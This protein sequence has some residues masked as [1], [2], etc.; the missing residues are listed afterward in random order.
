MPRRVG[1]SYYTDFKFQG[2]RIR[3]VMREARTADQAKRLEAQIRDRYFE[4]S[5]GNPAASHTLVD[6]A[7][8]VWLPWCKDN[9]KSPKG[10]RNDLLYF[11]SI[12]SFFG[13]RTF[14]EIPSLLIERFKRQRLTD[15]LQPASV[16]RELAAL[17]KIFRFAIQQAIA[18]INPVSQ[19]KKLIENNA[20]TRFLSPAE[21]A[22]LFDALL[23]NPTLST[24]VSLAIHTG[25]RQGEILK[26]EWRDV[27]FSQ[28]R[29]HIRDTKSGHDRYVPL[30]ASAR[31]ALGDLPQTRGIR[32]VFPGS[33]SS[34]HLVE[35][36]KAWHSAL[37]AA[38]IENFRF[39]DLRH[40]AGS[41]LA[42]TGAHPNTIKVLLGHRRLE[43][44]ERYMHAME[45]QKREAMAALENFGQT[46]VKEA[47]VLN[48]KQALND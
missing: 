1:N 8:K 38:A 13:N 12:M 18:T 28:S 39:H 36:K 9:R 43:T 3:K 42:A 7:E 19:V 5:Y 6:F 29:L 47:K 32:W 26:L 22:R 14:A 23:L 37:A 34:G 20:R 15:G 46:R 27:D 41:R 48:F 16:N 31:A 35:I 25:M 33:G 10:Y 21:E 2:Q 4:G 44:T 11:R 17:S 45:D 24:I 30:N 40:T